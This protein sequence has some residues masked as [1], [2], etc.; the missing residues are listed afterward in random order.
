MHCFFRNPTPDNSDVLSGAKWTPT[1]DYE[2]DINYLNIGKFIKN[3]TNP[4]TFQKIN[5]LMDKY[6]EGPLVVF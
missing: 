6:I 2:Y 4:I 3:G 5:D 1:K